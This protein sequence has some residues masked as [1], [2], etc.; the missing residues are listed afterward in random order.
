MHIY[1]LS[2]DK[3]YLN[4]LKNDI[5]IRDYEIVD[6]KE[7]FLNKDDVVFLSDDFELLKEIN[8]SDLLAYTVVIE[9]KL[10]PFDIGDFKPAFFFNEMRDCKPGEFMCDTYITDTYKDRA[11][12]IINQDLNEYECALQTMKD[13]RDGKLKVQWHSF[14]FNAGREKDEDTFEILNEDEDHYG[15]I[16]INTDEQATLRVKDITFTTNGWNTRD[17]KAF[18]TEIYVT[19]M[20]AFER[21]DELFEYFKDNEGNVNFPRDDMDISRK[22]VLAERLQEGEE[23]E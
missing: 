22:D 17:N 10:H 12:L 4:E 16:S 5:N 11:S 3:D 23:R 8:K 14:S 18:D 2:G 19:T 6:N 9:D 7:D 15:W 1:I 20:D 21:D 13:I